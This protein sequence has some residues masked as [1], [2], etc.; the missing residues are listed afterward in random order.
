MQLGGTVT[1]AGKV[2]FDRCKNNNLGQCS[3]MT[4]ERTPPE[5]LRHHLGI[6]SLEL[7]EGSCINF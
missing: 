3:D 7:R 2:D 1:D 5:N 4:Q 6:H